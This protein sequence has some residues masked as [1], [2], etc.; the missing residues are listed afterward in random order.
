MSSIW[1]PNSLTR[2]ASSVSSRIQHDLNQAQ[3]AYGISLGEIHYSCAGQETDKNLLA[4]C[5]DGLD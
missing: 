5:P 4:K 1:C 3:R 2:R